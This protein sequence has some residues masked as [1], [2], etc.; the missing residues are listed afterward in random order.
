M[1]FVLGRGG[2]GG[3]EE[4]NR[5]LISRRC[6]MGNCGFGSL[7]MVFVL[8]G[9]SGGE[10]GGG[11]LGFMYCCSLKTIDPHI[12]AMAGTEYGGCSPAKQ[13]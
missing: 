12:P 1:V 6:I 2:G 4:G 3:G 13:T 8:G 5:V 10:E 11:A 9:G 7:I